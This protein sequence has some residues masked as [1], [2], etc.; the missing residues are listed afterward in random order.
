MR[1]ST[2]NSVNRLFLPFLKFHI[3]LHMPPFGPSLNKLL[4]QK[5]TKPATVS[6][7]HPPNP[8]YVGGVTADSV[9]R[10]FLPFSNISPPLHM[11]LPP[12]P[13]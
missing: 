3:D 12:P 13:P 9:I 8:P 11:T 5:D 7:S 6:N 1:L 4:P 2:A 10:Y